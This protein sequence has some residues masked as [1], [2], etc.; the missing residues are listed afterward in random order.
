MLYT[1]AAHDWNHHAPIPTDPGRPG[2][3]RNRPRPEPSSVAVS[4]PKARPILAV[5]IRYDAA[6]GAVF[7]EGPTSRGPGGA[8]TA[9]AVVDELGGVTVLAPI[10]AALVQAVGPPRVRGD[11]PAEAAT[12]GLRVYPRPETP[13]SSPRFR[14]RLLAREK[15]AAGS[16]G[17]QSTRRGWS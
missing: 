14:P 2:L 5:S 17:W 11:G 15:A 3:T 6:R 9:P 12:A 1:I 4:G 13:I 16:A 8:W 7:A 10:P